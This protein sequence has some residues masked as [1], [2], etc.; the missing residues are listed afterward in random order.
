MRVP[1]S[2]TGSRHGSFSPAQLGRL[3]IDHGTMGQLGGIER[4]GMGLRRGPFGG[5]QSSD[6]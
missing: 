4:D 6:M 5:W 2:R 3:A 1:E